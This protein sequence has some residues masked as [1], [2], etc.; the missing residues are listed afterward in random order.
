M[1]STQFGIK[2]GPLNAV[3]TTPSHLLLTLGLSGEVASLPEDGMAQSID[4]WV[5]D[6]TDHMVSPVLG[7]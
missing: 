3:N 5:I 6:G 4:Q 2:H 7:I 1:E